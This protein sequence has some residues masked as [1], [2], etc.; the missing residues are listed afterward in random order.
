MPLAKNKQTWI[1]R[2]QEGTFLYLLRQS[3][4]RVWSISGP[5]GAGKSS[6]LNH[7]FAVIPSFQLL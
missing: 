3:E 1:N 2:P 4:M 5:G 7:A 6:L